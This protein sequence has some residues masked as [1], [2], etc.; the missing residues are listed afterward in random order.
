MKLEG[1]MW[2]L[3]NQ[4]LFDIAIQECGGIEAMFSIAE[5]NELAITDALTPGREMLVPEFMNKQIANYYRLKNLKP[6]TG[7]SVETLDELREEG[8]GYWAIEVDF[9]VS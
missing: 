2:V 1:N 6:A 9:V 8:I 5:L 7:I 4:S 3:D